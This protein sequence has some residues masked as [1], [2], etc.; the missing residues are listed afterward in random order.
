M[1]ISRSQAEAIASGF[2][3][4]LGE[5]KRPGELPII[6]ATLAVMAEGFINTANNNLNMANAVGSGELSKQLTF[7]V[8]QRGSTY[9]I[10][11]GYPPDSTAAIYWDFVN[12]GV[13]GV[14]QVGLGTDSPYKFRFPQAS[15]NHVDAIEAWLKMNGAGASNVHKPMNALETKRK[16]IRDT[17]AKAPTLRTLAY[18]VAVKNKRDGLRGTHFFDDAI[19]SSFG[20]DAIEA[21]GVALASEVK[22]SIRQINGELK[23]IN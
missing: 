6:E 1:G 4:T 16:G 22:L 11:I 13:Q 3:D 21:I 9:E 2:L 15:A 20:A 7:Y 12:K 8:E 5:N 19:T 18:A 17:I 14:Y 10:S 23:K